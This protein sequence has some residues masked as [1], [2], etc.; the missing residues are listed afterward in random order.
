MIVMKFGG[1]SVGNA[2]A[3]SQVASVVRHS[4]ARKPVV[5]VSAMT[6]I[7]DAL[8]RLAAK[9][10]EG[11]GSATARAIRS[12]HEETSETLGIDRHICARELRELD[13][14]VN[15]IARRARGCNASRPFSIVWRAHVRENCRG[16]VVER[17]DSSTRVRCLGYRHDHRRPF[18]PCRAFGFVVRAH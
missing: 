9:S 15:E 1:T 7:T 4:L 6:K 3:I 11:T 14:L 16:E 2:D 12:A 10:S 18:R 17:R 13:Q 8:I 5:V